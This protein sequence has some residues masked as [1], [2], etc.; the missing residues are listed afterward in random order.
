MPFASKPFRIGNG[1][2]VPGVV[3]VQMQLIIADFVPKGNKVID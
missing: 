3:I 1:S 2:A